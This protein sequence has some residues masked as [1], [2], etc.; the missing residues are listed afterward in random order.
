V[1]E[2]T[3]L[4]SLNA[5]V[6]AAR[7]GEYGKGFAIIA[8]EIR[9]LSNQSKEYLDR[10]VSVL[11][12]VT[13]AFE[14]FRNTL[15]EGISKISG[16]VESMDNIKGALSEISENVTLG[17]NMTNQVSD[18]IKEE[19]N[20]ISKLYSVISNVSE[21]FGATTS[22]I[23]GISS[24]LEEQMASMEELKGMTENMLKVSQEMKLSIERFEV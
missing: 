10:V 5:S 19:I 23:E 11:D 14:N 1:T 2:D 21:T 18:T 6:E 9:G 20:S 17:T 22:A 8:E 15:S 4:L 7:A 12:R 13:T 16:S 3:D 24:S